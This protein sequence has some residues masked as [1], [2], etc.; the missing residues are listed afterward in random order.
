[1]DV[2]SVG[3]K[4]NACFSH[5]KRGVFGCGESGIWGDASAGASRIRAWE[6]KVAKNV[7]SGR[8]VGG[9]KAG[10]A[11]S[12]LTSDVNQ[13]TLINDPY[14]SRNCVSLY[15]LIK[16]C[17]LLYSSTYVVP[18]GGCYKLIDIP[19]SNCINSG[20]NKIFIMTQYNSASLNRHIYRAF[21]FGNGINFGDGFVEVI[22]PISRIH[23]F[24]AS[25]YGI[26]K[27]DKVG[28]IIQFSEKPKGADLEAM[29]YIFE[30]Y[31]DDIGTTKSFYDANLALTEQIVDSIISHGC[32]LH[33]CKIEHSIV[34]V[35]SRIDYGAELKDALMLGADLYETEA[36]L[37]SILAEGKVPIG[38]GQ[39][40][41]IR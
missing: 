19:M 10:V 9:F 14:V 41:N 12:D 3:L 7:K 22:F 6:S 17:S 24:R 11:F 21:N 37:A 30:D 38:V 15:I 31:W 5:V 27:I 34:G 25:D 28:H 29:A 35:R 8:S 36:E 39:N 18:V 40:T 13:E 26:V 32:F 16:N 33:E 23:A 20:I 4:A 2:S 1:M